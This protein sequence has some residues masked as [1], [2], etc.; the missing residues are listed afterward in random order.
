[1]VSVTHR[2][3]PW[4]VDEGGVRSSVERES[5]PPGRL[6]RPLTARLCLPEGR[7]A[8]L[9]EVRDT[10]RLRGFFSDDMGVR[11]KNPTP[12]GGTIEGDISGYGARAAA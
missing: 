5:L 7:G 1:M 6:R 3:P 10:A 12:P 8:A 4:G 2:A 11:G 9:E